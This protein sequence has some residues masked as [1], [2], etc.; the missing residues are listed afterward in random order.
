MD[1]EKTQTEPSINFESYITGPN[2]ARFTLFPIREQ[3][4]DEDVR[5]AKRWLH[6]QRDVLNLKVEWSKPVVMRP[7]SEKIPD[8]AI[9]KNLQKEIGEL[10]SYIDELEYKLV[11]QSTVQNK[12]IKHEVKLDATYKT[13]KKQVKDV[14]AQNTKLRK[15]ISDLV[16]KLN[17][18]R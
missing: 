12:Q 18:E 3:H 15:D 8:K 5:K 1:L 14:V 7:S 16:I 11:Q 9:I 6:A 4:T 17:H 13:L 10:K 2:G